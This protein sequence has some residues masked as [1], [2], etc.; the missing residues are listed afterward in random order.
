MVK[1]ES[2]IP[3]GGQAVKGIGIRSQE[4]RFR[5]LRRMLRVIGTTR[6]ALARSRPRIA[7]Y[8]K[9]SI[10]HATTY[11]DDLKN[12]DIVIIGGGP[13]GLG[14]ACALSG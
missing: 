14:L 2:G 10:R 11:S 9:Y 6:K 8:G 4:I 7:S 5:Y 3:S 1:K 12:Y 13:V